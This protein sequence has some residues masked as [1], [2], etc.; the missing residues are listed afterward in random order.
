[1]MI[2]RIINNN[3]EPIHIEYDEDENMWPV[4][5]VCGGY[6]FDCL[7]SWA[8]NDTHHWRCLCDSCDF[9]FE[10]IETPNRY[11]YVDPYA[12]GEVL[13]AGTFIRKRKTTAKK[14]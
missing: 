6:T 13:E 14:R 1:M 2:S 7:D 10:Y 3:G 9:E 5:P 8:I 11:W 12:D 4:C